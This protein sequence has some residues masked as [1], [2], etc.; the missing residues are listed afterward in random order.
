MVLEPFLEG[1]P[2][3]GADLAALAPCIARLHRATQDWPQRPGYREAMLPFG[4]AARL[5][6]PLGPV[7][8]VH[9]DL[10][11]GNVLRLPSGRLALIDWEEAR[12]DAVRVDRMALARRPSLAAEV[13]ACW[14]A[15]PARARRL[16]RRAM[17]GATGPA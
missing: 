2:G 4:L 7:A 14:H 6:M 1:M 10:H 15:E 16:A 11:A 8:V 5:P 13:M 12:V 17:A 9:G 3:R